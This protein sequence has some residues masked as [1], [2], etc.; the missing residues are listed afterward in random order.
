MNQFIKPKMVRVSQAIELLGIGKTSLYRK[1][2]K[3]QFTI[4]RRDGAAYVP[5][6]Q[7]EA[8]LDPNAKQMVG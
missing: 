2:Q 3:G 4:I 6:E 1:V 5:T 7:I 8:Y